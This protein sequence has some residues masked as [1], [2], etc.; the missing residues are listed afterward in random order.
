M[1]RPST[2]SPWRHATRRALLLLVAI[3][4][5]ATSRPAGAGEPEVLYDTSVIVDELDP[6][7]DGAAHAERFQWRVERTDVTLPDT[8]ESC[9]AIAEKVGWKVV[10]PRD[11]HEGTNGAGAARVRLA[12]DGHRLLLRVQAY[13]GR[14]ASGE[15][16]R[17]VTFRF[18]PQDLPRPWARLGI[19]VGDDEIGEIKRGYVTLES[20]EGRDAA[21]RRYDASLRAAGWVP[22]GEPYRAHGWHG[23]RYDRGDEAME[24]HVTGRDA[25]KVMLALPD[26]PQ[27]WFTTAETRARLRARPEP[28]APPRPRPEPEAPPRPPKDGD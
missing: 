18:I 22:D 8:I 20:R 21:L 4:G 19:G 15:L 5:I 3:V 14:L 24:L 11:L 7:A 28:E 12:R 25:A 1:A 2:R 23:N 9:V 10:G 6:P 16:V 27:E 17:H 13:N 26:A